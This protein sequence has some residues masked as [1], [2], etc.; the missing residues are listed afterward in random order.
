VQ[1]KRKMLSTD[2]QIKNYLIKYTFP[3]EGNLGPHRQ[4]NTIVIVNTTIS[5]IYSF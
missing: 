3:D 2:L 4:Q 5:F 1:I